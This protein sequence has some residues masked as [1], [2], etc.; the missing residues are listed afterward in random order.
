MSHRAIIV[1]D[2]QKDYLATGKFPLVGIDQAI[3]NAGEVL[4]AAHRARDLV[5]HV[6]HEGPVDAPFFGTGTEGAEIVPAMEPA[7]GEA[8]ITKARPNAFHGTDLQSVLASAGIKDVVI[9]GA[10]SHMCIDATARAAVDFGYKTTVVADACA[11]R[12]LAFADK[13]VPSA[14]VHAA[15]MAALAFAYAEVVTTEQFVTA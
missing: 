2:L 3:A 11:T 13:T 10:M 9:V 1:V 5:I 6:R 7:T 14:M 12:D 4:A 15:F 8:V